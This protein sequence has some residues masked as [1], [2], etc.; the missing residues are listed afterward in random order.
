MKN[1]CLYNGNIHIKFHQ[2]IFINECVRDTQ[3]GQL[4][5]GGCLVTPD[6]DRGVAD[7]PCT[8]LE[9]APVLVAQKI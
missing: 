8:P 6:F 4:A 7:N 5:Q 2:I 1:L 3:R 9:T